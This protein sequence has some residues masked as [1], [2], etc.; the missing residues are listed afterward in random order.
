MGARGRTASDRGARVTTLGV[1]VFIFAIL[2]SIGLHEFGHFI[3][4][5]KFG[6]KVEQ[7]FIGFGPKLW[8]VKR[9]ETE[10]GVKALPFG[11]YVRIAGMNPFEE[12]PPED[13]DRV[14]KAKAPWKRAIVLSA[15][16]FTHFIIAIAII[17]GVLA[18][19]GEPD[20]DKPITTIADVQATFEGRPAPATVAGL[21]PGDVLVAIDGHDV[22]T[23]KDVTGLLKD[24]GGKQ[25]KIT[26]RRKGTLVT[27]STVLADHKPDGTKVGYLGIGP[28][29]ATRHY[30]PLSAIGTS[31]RRIGD[32][33]VASLQA[34]GKLFSPSSIGRLFSVASGAQK[35]TLNDPTTVVGLTGQAG[36]LLGR[37]DFAAFL[38]LIASFNVFIGVANLLPLPPLDGGHLAVLAYEKVRRRDVDMRR[39][40][41]ITVT[42]I[43]VFGSLFLLLLYLDIVHPLPAIPG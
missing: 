11:G 28:E 6:I 23:W 18:A 9:G 16:S 34:L 27:T 38:M 12:T 43:S 5:K 26:V 30:G 17:A 10:Y 20:F 22:S 39:L 2:F 8:S 31:G 1:I 35:R 40:I 21:K 19:V 25:A 33:I 41:P 14:F 4:A 42:V 32:G 7:F 24:R 37:G 29:F 15:G 36:G 13:K 3:T